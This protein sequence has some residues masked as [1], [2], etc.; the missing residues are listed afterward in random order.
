MI[1]KGEVKHLKG[2]KMINRPFPNSNEIVGSLSDRLFLN[3]IKEV[4]S[5]NEKYCLLF[6]SIKLIL[7]II[8]TKIKY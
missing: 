5:N 4:A 8:V 6:V 7:N 3:K 1:G 2:G